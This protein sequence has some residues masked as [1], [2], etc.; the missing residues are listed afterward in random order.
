MRIFLE[1]IALEVKT[2]TLTDVQQKPKKTITV[3]IKE[4]YCLDTVS[5][6]YCGKMV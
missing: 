1:S 5:N 3:V 6:N 4:S 2:S